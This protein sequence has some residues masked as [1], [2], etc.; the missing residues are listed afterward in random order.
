MRL[1]S[2]GLSSEPGALSIIG[3]HVTI[4][5]ADRTG[6][7]VMSLPLEITDE[8]ELAQLTAD[9][10]PVKWLTKNGGDG[11]PAQKGDDS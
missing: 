1:R 5:L 6:E 3:V 8:N 7:Q 9:L 10:R 2:L 11:E 4:A